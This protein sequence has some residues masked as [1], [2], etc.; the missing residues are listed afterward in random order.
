MYNVYNT[1]FHILKAEN[2]DTEEASFIRSVPGW[3]T[4]ISPSQPKFNVKRPK[5]L[6][7]D[8][9]TRLYFAQLSIDNVMRLYEIYETDFNMFDYKFSFGNITLPSLK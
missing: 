9:I 7:S 3:D 2:S 5:S 8:E 1:K 6:K 4:K